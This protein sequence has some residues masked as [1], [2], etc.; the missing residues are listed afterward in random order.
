MTQACCGS[1]CRRGP[2]II[3]AAS[4]RQDS[5][6]QRAA[7]APEVAQPTDMAASGTGQALLS[8]GA[9]V[10]E[11]S[12]TGRERTAPI[13][14]TESEM[15][16]QESGKSRWEYRLAG[17]APKDIKIFREG[18]RA[19]LGCIASVPLRDGRTLQ[20]L[21][22]AALI[23]AAPQLVDALK[24]ILAEVDGPPDSQPYSADSYLPLHL[25]EMAH[26]AIAKTQVITP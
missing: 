4:G 8:T 7:Q 5:R 20:G 22:D 10:D 25:R 2:R 13:N 21:T 1:R 6:Q 19:S 18:A 3:R 17:F 15:H 14:S 26:A 12:L 9:K 24:S 16:K 11:R 23:A